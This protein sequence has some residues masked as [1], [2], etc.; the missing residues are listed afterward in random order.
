MPPIFSNIFGSE[1]V[2]RSRRCWRASTARLS[3]R[4]VRVGPAGRVTSRSRGRRAGGSRESSG[5]RKSERRRG[6]LQ[7][8]LACLGEVPPHDD[9]TH[10]GGEEAAQDLRL[11]VGLGVRDEVRRHLCATE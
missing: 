1:P 6:S 4:S 11:V 3:S 8:A 7:V 9:K 2:A 10:G 5:K